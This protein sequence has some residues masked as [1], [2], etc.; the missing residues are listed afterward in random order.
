[1]PFKRTDVRRALTNK[2][3]LE[4][5]ADAPHPVF[6]FRHDGK[7]VARTH[8]SHSGKEVPDGIISA[9]ARQLGVSGPQLRDSISCR[10]GAEAFAELILAE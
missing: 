1:M 5:D 7:I 10:I 8:I 2:L 9:M 3:G 4:M 6:S